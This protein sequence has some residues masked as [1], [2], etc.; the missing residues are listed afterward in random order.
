M[1]RGINYNTLMPITL[2]VSTPITL[3]RSGLS[4]TYFLLAIAM[5]LTVLG[6]M[7]GAAF[8]APLLASGFVFLLF[9]A[10]FGIILTSRW[11]VRSTPLNYLLFAAF[12]LLSGLTLTPLILSILVGY[13][14]G[15]SILLNALAATTVLSLGAAVF[16][17]TT[18]IDLSAMGGFL[19]LSLLG[20]IVLGILQIF[21]PL[22]QSTQAEMLISGVGI[23]VFA[24]FLSFD[25]Q[26]LQRQAAIGQSPF[27]LALSLYLDVYNLFLYVLKFMLAMSGRRR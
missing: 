23:V 17:R 26:R 11:W 22:F 14:N 6:V 20:L 10:E 13:A 25:I 19:F 1:A 27:L 21:F 8:A 7:L 24:L 4:Q 12:P 9:I 18:D 16:A 2:P 15:A 3:G 5:A